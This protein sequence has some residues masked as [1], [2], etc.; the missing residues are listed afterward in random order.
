MNLSILDEMAKRLRACGAWDNAIGDRLS[1]LIRWI[2]QLDANFGYHGCGYDQVRR[3]ITEWAEA[4]RALVLITAYT[5]A[6]F[7]E[8]PA[9]VESCLTVAVLLHQWEQEWLR[10]PTDIR[11]LS[12]GEGIVLEFEGAKYTGI[13]VTAGTVFG[14]HPDAPAA[15]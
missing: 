6:T 2:E 11:F 8:I 9:A 7:T 12:P 14:T 4:K 1:F 10:P 3:P 5:R 15:D 13:I